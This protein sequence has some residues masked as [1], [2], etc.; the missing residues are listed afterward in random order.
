MDGQ[1]REHGVESLRP[2]T[3]WHDMDRLPDRLDNIVG[4]LET[5]CVAA[6]NLSCVHSNVLEYS[7]KRVTMVVTKKLWR[8][9]GLCSE[10]V[11]SHVTR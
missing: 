2:Y 6:E 10:S 4:S 5:R 11:F 3:L 1:N 8:R 7:K 9:G